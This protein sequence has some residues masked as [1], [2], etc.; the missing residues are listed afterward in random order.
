MMLC[1]VRYWHSIKYWQSVW[2]YA[3]WDTDTTYG[4]M[5]SRALAQRMSCRVLTLRMVLR[6]ARYRPSVWCYQDDAHTVPK[7]TQVPLSAYARA[8]QCPVLTQRTVPR[9]GA[10]TPTSSYREVLV[11]L[12]AATCLRG[13]RY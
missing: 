12:R 2:C 1:H 6:D 3:T 7:E 13:A 10:T 8:T 5:R 11:V 4:T 9:T